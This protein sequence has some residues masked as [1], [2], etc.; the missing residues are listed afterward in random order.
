MHGSSIVGSALILG[1]VGL[2]FGILIALAHRK[3]WVWEDPRIDAVANFLPG[4]N[5]GACGLAG[6]RSFAESLVTGA[7]QPAGC[8]VMSAED[9]ASVADFLGVE[10]GEANRRVARLLCAGGCTGAPQRAEYRGLGTCKAATAVAA[11]GKGC[12]WGCLGFGDCE[13]V[14]DL[15]AIFMNA[16]ELPVVIP[17]R[18]TAC[19][20]C[21]EAC[22]KDLFELMP[23]EHKL[24]V[25]CRSLLEGDGIEELCGVACTACGKCV[26]DAAPGLIS[27]V[28]G[29]AVIDYS[30][31]EL[32]SPDATVRCPT[33]A[34]VWVD[35]A[36][37]AEHSGPAGSRAA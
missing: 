8:T 17:E 13:V 18:C 26:Q 11:G 20:D 1:G 6:C 22:P 33:G 25:Q 2:T 23:M 35:G 14:C 27:M 30:K 3:L 19:G 32:A 15:D 31:N 29:L 37:F 7:I 9:I 36:Q 16:D 34:I 12:P 28:D 10:A 24:I 21:V 5:C 4:S